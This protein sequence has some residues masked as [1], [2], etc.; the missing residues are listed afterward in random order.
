MGAPPRPLDILKVL[1]LFRTPF[2]CF[3]FW[4]RSPIYARSKTKDKKNK[5][6]WISKGVRSCCQLGW[7]HMVSP[8]PPAHWLQERHRI[9]G[10][11]RQMGVSQISSTAAR[12]GGS[13]WF[14]WLRGLAMFSSLV[15]DSTHVPVA[16]PRRFVS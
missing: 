15:A 14:G 4:W 12:N 7:S 5:K 8:H 10:V 9:G 2:S 11:Q 13:S 6:T 1:G 16:V 3:G